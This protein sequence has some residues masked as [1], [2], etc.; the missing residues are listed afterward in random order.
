MWG[1]TI[2]PRGFPR[3][4]RRGQWIVQPD[5]EFVDTSGA[6]RDKALWEAHTIEL[7]EEARML[8]NW[9]EHPGLDDDDN[10]EVMDDAPVPGGPEVE[11]YEAEA[12]AAAEE[13]KGNKSEE[14][15]KSRL[16]S[17]KSLLDRAITGRW[18]YRKW[19]GIV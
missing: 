15:P 2:R 12:E 19:P 18:N 7:E 13:G 5:K 16:P 17:S 11:E 8:D 6:T 9:E 10:D 1:E 4:F 14:E 3:D